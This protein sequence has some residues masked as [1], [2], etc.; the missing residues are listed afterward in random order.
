M[1]G[2]LENGVAGP[3]A[4][5]GRIALQ[6][7]GL[8]PMQNRLLNSLPASDLDYLGEHLEAVEFPLRM[9]MIQAGAPVR[10]IYFIEEGLGSIIAIAGQERIEVCLVGNEGFVG[11]PLVLHS[12]YSHMEA[13]IQVAGHGFRMSAASL[14][15]CM[16][17]RPAIAEALLRF[18]YVQVTQISQTALANGRYTVEQ[19]LARWLLMA[20]D[21]LDRSELVLTHEFLAAMLGVRRPGVTV[22]LHVLE[23]DHAIRS[24]RGLVTIVNR[25]KLKAVA[26]AAY[27]RSESIYEQFFGQT[28]LAV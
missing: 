28:S 25:D 15:T 13:F 18:C 7:K 1:A 14:R 4:C 10:N 9:I 2:I 20:Q 23:G 19:R 26:G 22:A 5:R 3:F 24:R 21:R 27:G 8:L 11:L 12:D 6:E 16:A 17:E